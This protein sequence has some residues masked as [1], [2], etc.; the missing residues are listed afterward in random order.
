MVIVNSPRPGVLPLPNG[1][2][3]LWLINMGLALSTCNSLG[4][5]W[6][7]GMAWLHLQGV[8]CVSSSRS[9]RR[10]SSSFRRCQ[11]NWGDEPR[12]LWAEHRIDMKTPKIVLSGF[13][14]K[15][16]AGSWS[17]K[18]D[19]Q[20]SSWESEGSSLCKTGSTLWER[21]LIHRNLFKLITNRLGECGRNPSRYEEV[22]LFQRIRS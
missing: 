3:N 19:I 2:I 6:L 13:L 15:Y 14:E 17:P 11:T 21:D 8:C 5:P 22:C 9:M 4:W 7:Y 20:H 1:P 12:W 18:G 10:I 16:L